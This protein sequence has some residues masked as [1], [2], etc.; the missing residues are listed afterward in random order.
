[1][2]RDINSIHL[3]KV[4]GADNAH[5]ELMQTTPIIFTRLLSNVW[6]LVGSNKI[7]PSGWTQGIMVPLIK[8]GAQDRP[9][10][11]RSLCMLS[12]VRKA[13]ER[14][15][16]DELHE[17]VRKDYM[18]FGLQLTIDTLQAAI[19][20]AAVLNEADEYLVVVLDLTKAYDR[21]VR[22]ILIEKEKMNVPEDLINQI[23]EFLVPL[24]VQTNGEVT[25]IVAVLTTGWTRSVLHRLNCSG[26]S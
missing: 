9:E 3:N 15:V 11:Y 10:K 19:V 5:S 8:K 13:I 7:I 1:M 20:V 4:V 12:H 21:V 25:H 18:Q 22:A 24:L 16:V 6:E 2:R 26:S 14:A 23:I 17:I